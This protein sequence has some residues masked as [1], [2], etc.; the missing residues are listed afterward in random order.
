M[1]DSDKSDAP[2]QG[3][4]EAWGEPRFLAVGRVVRPHGLRGELLM[5]VLT[6]FPDR[7]QSVDTVF[8]G[9]THRPHKV[10]SAR[11]HGQDMLLNLAE[12]DGREAA[13]AVRGQWVS[14]QLADAADLPPGRYYYYQ[15][16]GLNVFT[17]EGEALGRVVEILETG[18]ND[19]YVV[20][21]DEREI[22]LP[23]IDT[24]IR[25]IDLE[26]GRMVVHLLEGLV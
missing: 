24:V 2:P 19:V 22:L 26:G 7:L 25:E 9:E 6:D 3:S 8:L 21:S 18:A 23:A 13:E 5:Q 11:R 15:I 12:I 20:R 1:D 10:E 17:E 16:E 4:P 14:I